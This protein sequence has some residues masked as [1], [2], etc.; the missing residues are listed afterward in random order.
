MSLLALAAANAP[1]AVQT[2]PLDAHTVYAIRISREAPTTC[3]FPGAL[4]ALEGAG[5]STKPEDAPAVLLSH[6]PGMGFFTVRALKEEAA[7][8][9]NVIFRNQVYALTFKAAAEPDRSVTFRDEAAA[10][11]KQIELGASLIERARANTRLAALHPT[12]R[13][14]TLRREPRTVT[15]YRNF[16]VIVAEVFRFDAEDALV[17]RLRLENPGAAPVRYDTAGLAV[18]VAGEIHPARAVD[19]SGAIPAHGAAEAWLVIGRSASGGRASLTLDEPFS[20]L[21]PPLAGPAP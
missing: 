10:G 2:Y 15:A 3:V 13:Q 1:G 6:E 16:R 7:A 21:V 12:L 19:A 17:F 14:E 20:I 8:A 5:V 11:E 9:V 4:T 18:R